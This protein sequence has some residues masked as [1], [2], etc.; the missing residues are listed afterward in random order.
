[1]HP[2]EENPRETLKSRTAL[3]DLQQK[4]R[5]E[6]AWYS[7]KVTGELVWAIS[8][9]IVA[10]GWGLWLAYAMSYGVP[11]WLVAIATASGGIKAALEFGPTSHSRAA[12]EYQAIGAKA[13]RILAVACGDPALLKTET[14]RLRT[15]MEEVGRSIS[16]Y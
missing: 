6:E 11:P 14:A 7:N 5:R 12:D 13:E 15:E 2:D 9:G 4:C 10:S 3:Y 16:S 1:M 8:C